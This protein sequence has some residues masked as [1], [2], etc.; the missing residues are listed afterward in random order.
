MTRGVF[1]LCDCGSRGK[2]MRWVWSPYKLAELKNRRGLFQVETKL[3]EKLL[4]EG[5]VEDPGMG[6]SK[7]TAITDKP[8]PKAKK[9][10]KSKKDVAET[11]DKA[12]APEQNKLI[13]ED[14]LDVVDQ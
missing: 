14:D 2:C 4:K 3:A 5:L 10:A 6:A 9:K 7:L 1:V 11:E 12:I 8:A 13:S